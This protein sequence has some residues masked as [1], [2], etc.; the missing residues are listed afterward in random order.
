VDAAGCDAAG[1]E[2]DGDGVAPLVQAE[3][4]IAKTA[5]GAATRRDVLLVVKVRSPVVE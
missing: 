4:T 2:A 5:N 1:D 3:A